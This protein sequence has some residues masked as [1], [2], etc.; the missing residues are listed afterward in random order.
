MMFQYV[1][2]KKNKKK[3]IET[4]HFLFYNSC[5]FCPYGL[6]Q[7]HPNPNLHVSHEKQLVQPF[8]RTSAVFNSYCIS[9]I[10]AW[11]SLPS[12]IVLCTSISAFKNALKLYYYLWLFYCFI[13]FFFR[14]PLTL[15][16][17]AI[18]NLHSVCYANRWCFSV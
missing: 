4:K 6:L 12:D 14:V 16:F 7:F 5:V 8:A 1:K 11:N 9:S 10:R 13:Y 17:F 3:S 2:N 15:A 18:R